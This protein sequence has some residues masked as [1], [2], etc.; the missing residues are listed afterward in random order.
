MNEIK[1][2]SRKGKK[3]KERSKLGKMLS[4]RVYAL[5]V[6][7]WFLGMA[8]ITW[9][10]AEDMREQV[11][12]QSFEYAS[13][14]TTRRGNQ[15]T[16]INFP[17]AMEAD[18]IRAINEPYRCIHI[19][20]LFP[21]VLEQIPSEMSSNDWYWGKWDLVYGMEVAILYSEI[22]G[23]T[24]RGNSES[25]FTS[26]NYLTF[27]YTDVESWDSG[28]ADARG[29]SYIVLDDAENLQALKDMIVDSFP[30]IDYGTSYNTNHYSLWYPELLRFE[31][32]F[33]GNE[34]P[35]TDGK[36]EFEIK[37]IQVIQM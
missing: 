20:S 12:E 5:G 13:S 26:G 1:E 24:I 34:F 9:A 28:S 23:D 10:V 19:Q 32:Y 35:L 17:G 6:G 14:L 7:L 22:D 36:K 15:D 30:T 4:R 21:I 37:H 3:E 8:L 33:E 25:I 2:D 29:L 18:M 11:V 27:A 16:P 31:G